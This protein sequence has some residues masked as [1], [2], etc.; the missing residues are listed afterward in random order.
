MSRSITEL[1][2]GDWVRYHGKYLQIDDIFG[3]SARGRLA[4]PSE[5]GFWV[6]T[7]SGKKIDMWHAELYL[8]D[9]DMKELA[10]AAEKSTGHK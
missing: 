2:P 10:N 9:E 1:K 3:V 8:T 4:K 7:V 5:G 6:T